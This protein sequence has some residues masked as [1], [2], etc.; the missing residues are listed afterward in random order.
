MNVV[1]FSPLETTRLCVITVVEGSEGSVLL[2]ATSLAAVIEQ[3][4]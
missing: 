4:I 1:C 3:L 2:V